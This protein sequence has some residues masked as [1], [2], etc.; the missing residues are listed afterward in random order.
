[1]S[2]KTAN[3]VPIH[4]Q[5][6]LSL[7]ALAGGLNGFYVFR[8]I[9]V[10]YFPCRLLHVT[11]QEFIKKSHFDESSFFSPNIYKH[12]LMTLFKSIARIKFWAFSDNLINST[13]REDKEVKIL[14]LDAHET[15]ILTLQQW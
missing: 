7:Y 15:A 1:M 5:C 4:T 3:P 10:D 8:T 14:N 2:Q 12:W 6:L 13:R 11:H 9:C